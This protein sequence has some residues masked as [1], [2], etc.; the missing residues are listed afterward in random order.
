[1]ERIVLGSCPTCG[2]PAQCIAGEPKVTYR[3]V[4]ASDRS[5]FSERNRRRCE[6]SDGF[7]HKLTDWSLSDWFTALVGEVGEA[8]NIVKK[9]NRIRDGIPGN[10]PGEGPAQLREAIGLELADVYIYLD[11]VAQSLGFD[12]M[13]LVEKKFRV[14]SEKI[15]YVEEA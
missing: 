12:M 7:N 5:T 4:H 3:P 15:G 10:V 13:T 11:L 14:T 8:G 1:M 2:G 9:L 6:S